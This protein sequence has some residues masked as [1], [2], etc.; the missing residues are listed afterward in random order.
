MLSQPSQRARDIANALP[1]F[2]GVLGETASQHVVEQRLGMQR[3]DRRRLAVFDR[4]NRRQEVGA[5]ERF[6]SCEHFVEDAAE[7]KDV[8]AMVA[9]LTVEP[10]GRHVLDRA[11]ET[12]RRRRHG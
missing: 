4:R 2:L 8:G 12:G 11:D 1:S 3:G 6:P 9:F 10:L 7:G 5:F